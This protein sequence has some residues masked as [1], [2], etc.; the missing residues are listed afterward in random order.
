[1]NKT[2]RV[3]PLCLAMA[4]TGCVN[5]APTHTVPDMPVEQ[6]W[7]AGESYAPQ[8]S[9]E[10]ALPVWEDFFR[11]DRLKRTIALG[12]ANNRDLRVM[13]LNVQKA[14]AAYGVKRSELFPHVAGMASNAAE[15]KAG[16]FTPTGKGATGHMYSAQLAMVGYELDFFGR[17][18][19]QNKSALERYL[20]TNDAKQVAQNALIAE[21]A[22]TWMRLGADQ[23]QLALQ[24][25]LLKSQE[26]SFALMQ[27]RYDLGALS[28][29]D[30]EQARTTVTAARAEIAAYVRRVA[31]D[32]NALSL[33]CGTSLDDALLPSTINVGATMDDIPVG[34]P[35]QVLLNRPDIIAAER[36][37]K[38]AEAD[39][40]VARAAFFPSVV[41]TGAVGSGALHLSDVLDPHTGMWSFV[42]KITLPIFTGGANKARLE[43]AK[44]EREIAVAQYEKAIQTAFREVS[45]ALALDGSIG[46]EL[47]ARRNFAQA[48]DNTY[49]LS[50]ASY[51][52][53]AISYSDLLVAQRAM[54][55]AKQLLIATELS[56][57]AGEVTLY[58]VL[59]GGIDRTKDLD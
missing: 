2:L 48:A 57:A 20:A 53:G 50:Q 1:M 43:V 56:K 36:T 31:Q 38:G 30:F 59:G 37:M 9:S 3:L 17:I 32:R 12:L 16:T 4:L 46:Q 7:P 18:R 27:K 40:G 11:D 6:S 15:H 45:D 39:I 29:L 49:R 42:P 41:L 44:T 21:I 10:Q 28:E 25:S 19:N 8:Q 5:L 55:S 54:V 34:L 58:K 52:A 51:D 24:R 13:A 26:E 14:R 22:M 23:D 35:A 47:Q 33:L